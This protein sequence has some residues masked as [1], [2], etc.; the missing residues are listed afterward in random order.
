MCCEACGGG[1]ALCG[2]AQVEAV[3]LGGGVG[4]FRATI[5]DSVVATLGHSSGSE[6]GEAAAHVGF[7]RIGYEV[8]AIGV[9]QGVITACAITDARRAEIVAL[10]CAAY[11]SA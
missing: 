8:F 1:G 2:A 4:R 7:E 5:L 6:E 11:A 9:C 10:H 3:P